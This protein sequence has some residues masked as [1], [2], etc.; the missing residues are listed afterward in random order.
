VSHEFAKYES[1]ATPN[2]SLFLDDVPET[3]NLTDYYGSL[4]GRDCIPD[5]LSQQL[6][7]E[8]LFEL[9]LDHDQSIAG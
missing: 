5:K 2:A 6:P 4:K 3:S 8:P 9:R 1:E 7:S